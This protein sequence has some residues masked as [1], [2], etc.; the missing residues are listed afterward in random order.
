MVRAGEKKN[1]TQKSRNNSSQKEKTPPYTLLLHRHTNSLSNLQLITIDIFIPTHRQQRLN[2]QPPPLRNSP[3]RIPLMHHHL[4]GPLVTQQGHFL[5]VV[6]RARIQETKQQANEDEHKQGK[7]KQ[8]AHRLVMGLFHNLILCE[9]F[10]GA[11]DG[12]L[13]NGVE[14]AEAV[15][16]EGL[17]DGA[18]G[19]AECVG[20]CG[21]VVA[22]AGEAFGE[23]VLI[24]GG[25]RG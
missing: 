17:V 11:E 2:T 13:A 24:L 20:F 14:G 18:I 1:K 4:P 22:D 12:P 5:D 7:R 9:R 21:L 6:I 3:A 16:G 10:F 25:G 23:A 8:H 19:S 15:A